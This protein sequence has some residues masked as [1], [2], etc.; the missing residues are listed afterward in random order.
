[1]LLCGGKQIRFSPDLAIF[2]GRTLLDLGEYLSARQILEQG[3]RADTTATLTYYYLAM[4]VL[5]TSG[6]EQKITTYLNKFLADQKTKEMPQRQQA[7]QA[8]R[9]LERMQRK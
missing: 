9:E 2:T 8:L 4:A 1:M 7:E 5:A 6:E 3:T